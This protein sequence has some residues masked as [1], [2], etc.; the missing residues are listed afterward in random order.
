MKV[1]NTYHS[2]TSVTFSLKCRLTADPDLEFLVVARSNELDVF[3]I[4]VDGLRLR[5]TLDVWGRVTSLKAFGSSVRPSEN[6]TA[7]KGLTFYQSVQEGSKS[8]LLLT[9]DHPDPR[10]LL[11]QYVP[12]QDPRLECT[13]SISLHERNA[14][15]AEF[16]CSAI[17]N[18]AGDVA[19]VSSYVGK[20]K[21]LE[22][23]DGKCR[24]DFNTAY[25]RKLLDHSIADLHLLSV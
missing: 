22:L 25:I 1:V 11:L 17:V 12:D 23:S 20:L 8:S 6:I 19:V 4:L 16:F 24:S 7:N 14:R 2:P 21:V 5:C 3:A 15:P 18:P 9:T 13:K 10:L